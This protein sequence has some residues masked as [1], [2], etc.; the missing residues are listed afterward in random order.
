MLR[1]EQPRADG[2]MLAFILRLRGAV[3]VHAVD[4]P[5]VSPVVSVVICTHNRA[6][7][8]EGAIASVLAQRD[9]PPHETIVV[10]NCSSDN[11]RAV[12]ERHPAHVRYVYEPALGL[13]YARNTGWQ[14]ARGRYIA[15]LDDDAVAG[16][17]WLRAIVAAYEQF[18]HAG[19]VGGRVEPIWECPPPVWLSA[20]LTRALSIIHWSDTPLVIHDPEV[21]WI[22][23]ANMAV[24]RELLARLGGFALELGRRGR[25]LMSNDEL[26]V[27]RQLVRLGHPCLY[28][29]EMAV[30]HLVPG[31]RLQR[32][33]FARRYFWQGVSDVAMAFSE[34]GTSLAARAWLAAR[35]VARLLCEP[36]RLA[37]AFIPSWDPVTVSAQCVT[38][39]AFGRLAGLLGAA[40]VRPT[41]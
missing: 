8:L 5:S 23:G 4:T 36:L 15:Y 21:Q 16:P 7:W 29:P 37:R 41:T 27:E 11:T 26:H 25:N 3:V 17:G 13:G 12:V 34:N 24:P 40:G 38:W 1:H 19:V 30:R 14:I 32:R 9:P 39:A 6:S 2:R 20:K 18:P 10:D 28:Y 22:V 35:E 33:W 31:A